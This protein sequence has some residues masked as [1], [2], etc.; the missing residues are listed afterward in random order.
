MPASIRSPSKIIGPIASATRSHDVD[1][2][3]STSSCILHLLGVAQ[4][5][6]S[7]IVTTWDQGSNVTLI[8]LPHALDGFYH[9]AK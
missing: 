2:R 1:A 5:E 7:L 3:G 8:G 4:V 6:G 9:L